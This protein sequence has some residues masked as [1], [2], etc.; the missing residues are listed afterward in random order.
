MSGQYNGVRAKIKQVADM[1]IHVWCYAHT[2]NL[3]L[4][5]T[6]S[7]ITPAMSLF[8]LL[9]SVATFF[10]ESHKRMNQW[11]DYLAGKVGTEK[12]KKLNTIGKTRW[13]AKAG[14]IQK[15]FGDFDFIHTEQNALYIDMLIILSGI[16]HNNEFNTSA[17]DD[18]RTLLGKLLT[19]ETIVTATVFH[20]IFAITTP[21]SEYLQTRGVDLMQAW[22]VV[23]SATERLEKISRDFENI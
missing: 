10:R 20:A 3:V 19:F 11:N 15:V 13:W 12:L 5:D 21:L 1:H 9:N 7:A 18:A 2:L 17:R 14:A 8:A 4:G 23:G 22:R 6:T 16:A